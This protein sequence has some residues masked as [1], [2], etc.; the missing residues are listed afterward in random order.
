M[1]NWC[2]RDTHGSVCKKE[3]NNLLGSWHGAH[4]QNQNILAGQSVSGS[5]GGLLLGSLQWLSSVRPGKTPQI[6]VLLN[7][8]NPAGKSPT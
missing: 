5:D 8:Y 1:N 6:T 2:W 3:K 4:I 7:S